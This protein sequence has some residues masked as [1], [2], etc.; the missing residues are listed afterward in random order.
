MVITV[1]RRPSPHEI[2]LACFVSSLPHT[3]WAAS[4]YLSGR[5]SHLNPKGLHCNQ[6]E[7]FRI[8]CRKYCQAKQK[9]ETRFWHPAP[10][11]CLTV[12]GSEVVELVYAIAICSIYFL[13]FFSSI[14]LANENEIPH[15]APSHYQPARPHHQRSNTTDIW[16]KFIV[17]I[18]SLK[19]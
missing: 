7:R 12:V 3:K 15:R 19:T 10:L 9:I 4:P 13:D 11:R 17:S 5:I 6:W 18:N 16:I 14:H 1:Q 8:R 2:Q